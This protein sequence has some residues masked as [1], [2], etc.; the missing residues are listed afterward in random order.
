M[1]TH[2][3]KMATL[4]MEACTGVP[5]PLLRR[6]MIATIVEE[7]MAYKNRPLY[8]FTVA[9]REPYEEEG[10]TFECWAAD[11]EHACEQLYNAQ[12]GDAFIRSCS[13]NYEP[14]EGSAPDPLKLNSILHEVCLVLNTPVMQ[15][16][17]T[18]ARLRN[19][20]A[21]YAPGAMPCK[22]LK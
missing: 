22:N 12:G 21:P 15:S 11:S 20:L 19:S 4:C 2:H 10:G 3:E 16:P 13:T 8:K 18:F 6:G 9:W 5:V 7:W 14:Y 1:T 17:E